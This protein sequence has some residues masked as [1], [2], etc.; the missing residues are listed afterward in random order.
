[1]SE[2]TVTHRPWRTPDLS[3][4]PTKELREHADRMAEAFKDR[5]DALLNDCIGFGTCTIPGEEAETLTVEVLNQKLLEVLTG[6]PWK[7]TKSM[8]RGKQYALDTD[9]IFTMKAVG[10]IYFCHPDDAP[11][12]LIQLRDLMSQTDTPAT[13]KA[14]DVTD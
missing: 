3:D 14:P 12:L 9:Q 4:I 2:F 10:K 5:Q 1:M 7:L 13:N 11:G 6:C 8:P